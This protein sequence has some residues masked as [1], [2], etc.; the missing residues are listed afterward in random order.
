MAQ[1]QRNRLNKNATTPS[2]TGS[3]AAKTDPKGLWLGIPSLVRVQIGFTIA[4][5]LLA[6]FMGSSPDGE[7]LAP[8]GFLLLASM[9]PAVLLFIGLPVFAHEAG[10]ALAA[11]LLGIRVRGFNLLGTEFL[12]GAAPV[13]RKEEFLGLVRVETTL[14]QDRPSFWITFLLAGPVA[15][16]LF[17]ALEI[18]AATRLGV[19]GN[20]LLLQALYGVGLSLSTLWPWFSAKDSSVK[21]DGQKIRDVCRPDSQVFATTSLRRIAQRI[22]EGALDG[23][24]PEDV[25][26]ALKMRNPRLLVYANSLNV[27]W[28]LY[29]DPERATGAARA[30]VEAC[31]K[32][33]A[34]QSD[35][36]D[37]EGIW[38]D[39]VL[40]C[41]YCE[42]V[43][44]DDLDAAER[45]LA[46]LTQIDTACWYTARRV[47]AAL[48]LRRGE[49]EKAL[50][51]LA[52]ATAMLERSGHDNK[53]L[54]RRLLEWVET[55]ILSKGV[56][57]TETA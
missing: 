10:H 19:M 29:A 26:R 25:R 8:Y 7:R 4:G 3:P 32:A 51:A 34:L 55:A 31:E 37:L 17:A 23:I 22:T 28:T 12:P 27:T 30:Y 38:Q 6:A 35:W 36:K 21:T 40:E 11:W 16:L 39:A 42:L 48:Y 44:E 56:K 2:A 1:I 43:N 47:D 9:F 49:T 54:E 24:D 45:L 15:G 13:Q 18:V 5:A 14:P 20:L 41:A 57:S 50:Q 33:R 52:H 46:K 53:P